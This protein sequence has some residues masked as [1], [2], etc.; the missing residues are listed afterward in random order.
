MKKGNR[1]EAVLYFKVGEKYFYEQIKYCFYYEERNKSRF[2]HLN[3][4]EK[5][6]A[7][8]WQI[9]IIEEITHGGS[10][11]DNREIFQDFPYP[12]GPYF[13]VVEDGVVKWDNVKR[14]NN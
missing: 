2:M 3:S 12:R 4:A 11:H 1:C 10:C 8:M 9:N 14:M 7:P 5:V 6:A 13:V